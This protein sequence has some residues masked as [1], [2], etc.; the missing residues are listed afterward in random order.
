M[1]KFNEERFYKHPNE[2]IDKGTGI[3]YIYALMNEFSTNE[4]YVFNNPLFLI[5]SLTNT[6]KCKLNGRDIGK[7][8]EHLQYLLDNNYIA[9]CTM[10]EKGL[11]ITNNYSFTDTAN[12]YNIKSTDCICI[13]LLQRE[14]EEGFTKV[15]LSDVEKLNKLTFAEASKLFNTY[16]AIMKHSFN[17]DVIKV[18]FN[19][20]KL[21]SGMKSKNSISRSVNLLKE[22][23][24]LNK[25]NDMEGTKEGCYRYVRFVNSHL[26]G[27]EEDL[28]RKEEEKKERN[29]KRRYTTFQL[30]ESED[31]FGADDVNEIEE[32]TNNNTIKEFPYSFE[33]HKNNCVAN[34]YLSVNKD[35]VDVF[36]DNSKCGTGDYDY[37]KNL[38]TN[39]NVLNN[40]N[41]I[42]HKLAKESSTINV[43]LKD[44]KADNFLKVLSN[45]KILKNVVHF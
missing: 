25:T 18:S 26:L 29:F 1:I 40:K 43:V 6:G 41:S 14:Y 32:V 20:I 30:E 31:I 16:V 38:L 24:I 28:K 10:T 8:K 3:N 37:I 13:K 19:E 27:S 21:A 11:E 15:Y 36:I 23:E 22:Y 34:S 2:L 12:K 7:L 5:M 39:A 33:V 42:I 35:T 44:L 9:I 17:A 45:E 4:K